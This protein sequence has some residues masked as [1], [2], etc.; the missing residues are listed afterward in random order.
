MAGILKVINRLI[1]SLLLLG[2]EE[3]NITRDIPNIYPKYKEEVGDS[4]MPFEEWFEK[5]D[6]SDIKLLDKQG[7]R[8]RINQT[9]VYASSSKK[10]KC[11]LIGLEMFATG[12]EKDIVINGDDLT[13]EHIIPQNY[14]KSTDFWVYA[15]EESDNDEAKA[16]E[17]ITKNLHTLPNLT[18]ITGKLNGKLSNKSFAEKKVIMKDKTAF[19]LNNKINEY[20]EWREL[21]LRDRGD[22]LTN[23]IVGLLGI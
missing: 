22:K 12:W 1:F 7:F 20:S 18:I 15:K 16:D 5:R 9:S 21:Q 6:N 10:T 19:D 3:K 8:K 4:Q 23:L 13:I 14:D 2:K 11:L 17:W